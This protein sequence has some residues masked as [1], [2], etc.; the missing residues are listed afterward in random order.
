M[1]SRMAA[2]VPGP[3]FE[4][5]EPGE[6]VVSISPVITIGIPKNSPMRGEDKV[7]ASEMDEIVA[8]SET[9]ESPIR[10]WCADWHA[11]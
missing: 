1:K 5:G 9:L 8:V 6:L 3:R 11:C 10:K 7:D 4:P 2:S